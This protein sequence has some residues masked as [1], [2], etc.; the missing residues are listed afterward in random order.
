[1]QGIQQLRKLVFRMEPSGTMVPISSTKLYKGGYGFVGLAVYVPVTANRTK[2]SKPSVTVQRTV[3]DSFGNRKQFNQDKFPLEYV[4]IVT[5][6]TGQ[7]MLFER[8][9]P[10][11]FTDTEGELEL[12]FS[13]CELRKDEHG[14]EV[15]ASRL[16]TSPYVLP[17]IGGVSFADAPDVACQVTAQ[18]NANTIAIGTLVNDVEAL[19]QPPDVSEANAV[20][21]PN[22]KI[23]DEGNLKFSNL[24]GATF[25]PAIS[26]DGVISWTND[27]ELENPENNTVIKQGLNEITAFKATIQDLTD[28]A[29]SD[30]ATALDIAQQASK[31]IAT[32]KT[33]AN[34]AV[35][36]A[37]AAALAASNAVVTANK[38][39][40]NVTQGIGTV[41]SVGGEL[42]SALAY[43]SDPQTQLSAHD[44]V[45]NA[46]ATTLSEHDNKLTALDAEI[47]AHEARYAAS[48]PA[49]VWSDSAAPY[50]MTIAASVHGKGTNPQWQFGDN[51]H[52]CAETDSSG[53]ISIE[54]NV[55][56]AFTIMIY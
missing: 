35:T 31:D 5:L 43:T 54:S 4:E 49:S 7:Y 42:Q 24:K 55:K 46:H 44:G 22:V 12:V 21:T 26:E 56:K 36:T 20:G 17:V 8:P 37:S 14:E 30:A 29:V 28:A 51:Q 45:L 3:V 27:G 38:A 25:T 32:A 48:Y 2:D 18:E 16:T 47:S 19:L 15:V 41:V 50:T 23:T 40:E 52:F 11:T 6:D 53:N 13:Y 34:N 9:M 10:K 33:D 1:M 39:M